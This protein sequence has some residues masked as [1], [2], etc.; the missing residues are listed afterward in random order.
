MTRDEDQ[1]ISLEVKEGGMVTFGDN[2]K[3]KILR[4]EKVPITSSSYIENVL[5]VEDLKHN[6]VSISQLC[7][8]NFNV[9]F[10]SSICYVACP[11][12]NNI[13]FSGHRNENVY[14]A[15]LNNIDISKQQ[16]L[17]A[18]NANSNESSWLWHRRLAYTNM[19]LISKLSRK[20]LV[21]GLSK[22]KYEINQICKACQLE[23]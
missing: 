20:D 10:R 14:I 3:D 22:L 9:S 17:V 23:K 15:D 7:D 11:I 18:N 13:A 1:F 16:C 2:A 19:D 6:L 8:K 5:F 4:F 12:T 21:R